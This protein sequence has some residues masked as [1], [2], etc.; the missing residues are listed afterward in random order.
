MKSINAKRIAAVAASLLMGLAFAG[1]G[2]VTWNNVPI[3]SNAGVPSVQVVVGS[4]AAPSDGVVAANIAAVLGNLAFTSQNVTATPTGLSNVNCVVTTPT[5]TLTNQQVWFGEKGFAG[6][7]GSYSF[8][9]LIGSVLNQGVLLGAPSYTKNT[10]T[11]TTYAFPKNNPYQTQSSPASSPFAT[12]S[13][14]T[15]TT[16]SSNNGGGLVFSSGF[17]ATSGSSKYDNLLQ[18]T[19][20]QL[21]ALL[22]NWGTN[23][24][25]ENLWLTG[26]PVYDQQQN[27]ATPSQTFAV[28]GVGGAYQ[29]TFNKAIQEPYYSSTS[30]NANAGTNTVNNAA[31]QLLGQNWTVLNYQNSDTSGTPTST[32]AAVGGKLQLAASLTPLQTVYVGHNITSN[33]F[34]VSLTDLGQPANGISPAAVDVYYKGNLTNVTQLNPGS[35]TK[36]QVGTHNL[37]VKVNQTFAGLYAYQK[38]AKLKLYSNT[39][40]I[41]SGQVFN[42]TNAPGWMAYLYW[43]NGTSTGTLPNQLKSIVIYNQSPAT[44]TPG[45]SFSFVSPN[46]T[47]YKI[48]FVGDTLG[49][50]FDAISF[51]ASSS[52]QGISLSNLGT[53]TSPTNPSISNLTQQSGQMLT[54]T[55]QIPDSFSYAGQVGST[56]TYDLTP[57][58]L[59]LPANVA[60]FTLGSTTS[61]NTLPLSLV[62]YSTVGNGNV[63]SPSNPLTVTVAG[64]QTNGGGFTTSSVQVAT[65]GGSS[66]SSN[67]VYLPTG[68]YNVTNMY[69]SQAV[70][71]LEA[72]VV[73]GYNSVTPTSNVIASYVPVGPVVLYQQSGKNYKTAV[74]A[75]G[76]TFTYNQQNGQV[77]VSGFGVPVASTTNPVMTGVQQYFTVNVP[78]YNV[79]SVTSS[80]D[81][82]SFGIY[83]STNGGVQNWAFQ[84][85]ES[86]TGT[87]NNMT[88]IS[89]QGHSVNAPAGFVTERG[90]KVA[91]IS[92]ST[93]VVNYAKTVDTLQFVVSPAGTLV[94]STTASKTVGPVGVGQSVPGFANLTVSAVNA[95]CSG[96]SATS[97]ACTVTGLANVSATPSV[98]HAV[99]PVSLNTATTPLVVL[100]SN[101]NS[102][103]TLVVV[104]SKYVNSVAAQIFAQQ[105]ALN[106]RF[107]PSS[108]VVQQYGNNR[109]LVAGYTA[110]Q[111]V[112]AGNQFINDLLQA[113]TT[114]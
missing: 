20:T 98:S 83:N 114:Q 97:S 70:P 111:T 2:G 58:K 85:N 74:L 86:T 82:L 68:F 106:S 5:C 16:V 11:S 43:V 22:N 63:I 54:V 75:S 95:T 39:M 45:Q 103:S 49:N 28:F 69:F 88:Y 24:E 94:N 89:S 61:A 35:L 105:P 33:N 78:E 31:I 56:I 92:P 66:A 26:F 59:N 23:G 10:Q 93:D 81:N 71:Y 76:T 110:N 46:F 14:P 113:A 55:S 3:I 90:S 17:T 40:N 67:T 100:D 8:T 38:W 57:N 32:S 101:A 104:G 21:S 18:I 30:L 60:T 64:Y 80:M 108:V 50:N 109:I 9:A 91:S 107:G 27:G 44:L 19:P 73:I 37:Y 79:P 6:P 36:F 48:N 84:L 15:G 7:A 102:A 52:N 62:L 4:Q 1:Q 41:T 65:L 77:P 34:S 12:V 42:Q 47:T 72:N 13:V 99:V 112:Q 96:G 87:K 25:T 53:S 51:S 29:I